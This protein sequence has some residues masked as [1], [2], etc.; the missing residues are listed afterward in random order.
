VVPSGFDGK[1]MMKEG[2]VV[3]YLGASGDTFDWYGMVKHVMV[4]GIC[5]IMWFGKSAQKL[6]GVMD[7]IPPQRLRK[8]N[9]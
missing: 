9:V 1:G 8:I 6:I 2:D 7:F 4:D 3:Q 5:E